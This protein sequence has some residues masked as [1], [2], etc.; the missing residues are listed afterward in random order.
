MAR[1][2]AQPELGMQLLELV[3]HSLPAGELVELSPTRQHR[4]QVREL[5]PQP[6]AAPIPW[7]GAWENPSAG[8]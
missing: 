8:N 7:E 6:S 3:Q 2:W 4:A 1:P 5:K